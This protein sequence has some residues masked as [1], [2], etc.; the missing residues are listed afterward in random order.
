MRNFLITI[1]F[2]LSLSCISQLKPAKNK[3]G[4]WGYKDAKT[5]KTLPFIYDYTYHFHEGEALVMKNESHYLIDETGKQLIELPYPGLQYFKKG[6]YLFKGDTIAGIVSS[7]GKVLEMLRFKRAFSCNMVDTYVLWDDNK[8]GVLSL[9]DG[10]IIPMEYEVYDFNGTFMYDGMNI[11][12]LFFTYNDVVCLKHKSGK[13]GVISASGRIVTPFI[14]DHLVVV[15]G[16]RFDS[17]MGACKDKKWGL[18]DTTGK[19]IIPFEYDGFLGRYGSESANAFIFLKNDKVVFY[20]LDTKKIIPKV[21]P[22]M[23]GPWV[24]RYLPVLKEDKMGAIDC[25]GNILVPFEYDKVHDALGTS[26]NHLNPEFVI[27]K[28]GKCALFTSAKGFKT[29]MLECDWI[30]EYAYKDKKLY[31]LTKKGLSA[32]YNENQKPIT[33]FEFN[34][35]YIDEDQILVKKGELKG[36]MD[37]SGKV[38]WEPK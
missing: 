8:V 31:V 28:D 21:E 17:K 15:G 20:D 11:K 26:D 1:L 23:D 37:E 38:T 18:I 12:D 33:A 2:L 24:Q 9:H 29:E 32:L 16:L 7:D 6:Q 30:S 27:C 3:E 34:E 13:W 35:L 4:K 36:R 19:E 5:G 22:L 14:Y 10:V 25:E